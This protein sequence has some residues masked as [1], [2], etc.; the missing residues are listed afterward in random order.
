MPPPSRAAVF[1]A[2]F[3]VAL[4]G[5]PAPSQPAVDP[6]PSWND[7]PAKERIRKF[8]AATTDKA[9][10]DFVPVEQRVA[11]FDNDGTLWTEQPM[12]VEVVFAVDRL[13]A[14][15]R[16]QPELRDRPRYKEILASDPD[17]PPN[18][19]GKEMMEI[20]AVTHGGMTTAEFDFL[21]KDWLAT[22]QHPRF[23]RPY[24]ELV[25]QPMLELLRYLRANGFKT[26]IVSGG[27]VD[28]MRAFAERSYGILPEQVVGTSI[29]TR[30]EIRQG[31]PVLYRLP[32]FL[33]NDNFAGKPEGIERHIG[34][35]PFAAFGNSDGD[36]QMLEWTAAGGGA[37]LMGLVHHD[38][39]V[40]EYTY[41][42]NSEVGQL[43]KA[44]DEAKRRDWL[45]VSM[46]NDWR[47]IYPFERK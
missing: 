37:R 2:L 32:E 12:Y 47:V 27:G 20:T 44:W 39:A 14:M 38:D 10:R 22:H 18:L 3:T 9:G 46:K 21:V 6:L 1:L 42:R 24:T 43:D 29:V 19:S 31:I 26:Y 35:R 8:V 5:A 13:R 7:T 33:F 36:Q 17:K 15:A 34:R 23:K 41:D 4:A 28:F 30:Y 16:K 25:Y 40:R 11:T 45:V